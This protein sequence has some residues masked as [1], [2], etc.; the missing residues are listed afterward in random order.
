M[1]SWTRA[2]SLSAVLGIRME[3]DFDEPFRALE[4]SG[5]FVRTLDAE[6]V[7]YSSPNMSL[8]VTYN[9]RDGV[10][11]YL[12]F[13]SSQLFVDTPLA[14]LFACLKVFRADAAQVA[15]P[16]GRIVERVDVIRHIGIG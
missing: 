10:S 6:S 8:T 3:G 5:L 14:S 16:P 7:I 13:W 12:A 15:M 9:W 2:R 4:A 1:A 11:G